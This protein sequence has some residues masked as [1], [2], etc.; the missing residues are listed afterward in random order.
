MRNGRK[1]LQIALHLRQ[2]VLLEVNAT[3]R[4]HNFV[5]QAREQAVSL[6]LRSV[7]SEQLHPVGALL[8]RH[9]DELF[10]GVL[11]AGL[12]RVRTHLNHLHHGDV[13]DA[14][15]QVTEL[16]H[17]VD[18]LLVSEELLL[19]LLQSLGDLLVIHVQAVILLMVI[20][21]LLQSLHE[22]VLLIKEHALTSTIDKV[23][24]DFLGEDEDVVEGS[25]WD[26][27]N[28][29]LVLLDGLVQCLVMLADRLDA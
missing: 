27:C 9:R 12:R 23:L 19:D 16:R 8:L 13:L 3:L 21:L 11:E 4:L 7:H 14:K 28:L 18:H 15:L 5:V 10:K 26:P 22:L 6:Q 20:F 25:R 29:H 1:Q 2:R 24:V 17:E